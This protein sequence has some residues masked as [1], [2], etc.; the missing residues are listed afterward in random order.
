MEL[1]ISALTAN[2]VD[3]VNRL[4]KPNTGTLGFLPFDALFD[5]LEKGTALGAKNPDG[6]LAG[7][8]LY[9][10]YPSRFRIVHLCVAEEH[11]GKGIAKLLLNEL[12]RLATTQSVVRL[13]C[14]RDFSAHSLWP[15]LGFIPVDEKPGRSAAGHLL[16]LWEYQISED[17]QLDL[18]REKTSNQALDVV[19]DAQI[20]FHL[21]DALSEETESSHALLGDFLADSIDLC[22]T[23][24]IFHEIDRQK[25]TN[26]RARSRQFAHG[27]RKVSYDRTIAAHYEKTL[28]SILAKNTASDESDIRHLAKTAASE[29]SVFVTQDDAILARATE[30]EHETKLLVLSPVKLIVQIHELI[31][32]HSYTPTPVSGQDLAWRRLNSDNLDDLLDHFKEPSERKGQLRKQINQFL[33]RPNIYTSEIFGSSDNDLC[34]RM[35]REDTDILRIHF[36]RTVRSTEQSLFEQYL[37]AAS[38]QTCISLGLTAV[39]F[40]S[41]FLSMSF[42]AHLL[43]TGFRETE[44][45]FVRLCLPQAFSRKEVLNKFA[46]FHSGFYNQHNRL[47][48]KDLI[49]SCSPVGYTSDSESYFI[50]PI[51]P[52][53]AISLFDT[54]AASEDFFGGRSRILMRWTN[55][56]Y[57]SKTH[58]K[59]LKPPGRILWYVSGK[60]GSIR[61]V[62][63]LDAIENGSPKELYRKFRRFGTLDWPDLFEMCNQDPSKEIM[64]MKFSHTFLFLNPVSLAA[65]REMEGRRHVPLQSPRPISRDM[66]LGIFQAGFTGTVL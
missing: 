30:I 66:F 65:L 42:R 50:I 56:Y 40:D 41:Y 15:K 60:A 37:I 18:F 21:N 9:A 12:L 32:K 24:E 45:G 39:R 63:H 13:N 64:A 20:L 58:H 23:D 46:T 47:S 29:V 2:D 31:E 25:N 22:V 1:T 52:A 3:S 55:V 62:S 49:D 51:K 5:F 16:T 44:N 11:R 27:F 7:Y 53:Y 10:S 17:S 36:A 34:I 28:S 61:A 54:K 19:I 33:A 8:I 57:R 59:V 48:A 26:R 35:Y 43:Q 4:M 38:L 6:N 14:R